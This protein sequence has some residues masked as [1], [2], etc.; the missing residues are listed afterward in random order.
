M[1]EF[2]GHVATH[3]DSRIK[4][5][6]GGSTL[7]GE[8]MRCQPLRVGRLRAPSR[9][10]KSLNV[11]L[12]LRVRSGS[13]K[14]QTSNSYRETDVVMKLGT[15]GITGHDFVNDRRRKSN[16][17]SP[18]VHSFGDRQVIVGTLDARECGGSERRG[19]LLGSLD[20]GDRWLDGRTNESTHY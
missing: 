2:I 17:S 13:K 16:H 4:A 12:I 9:L 8:V 10:P 6:A 14:R 7:L 11:P 1:I 15:N 18:T 20:G 5:H 3:P 19:A